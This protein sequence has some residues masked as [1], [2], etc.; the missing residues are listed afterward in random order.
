[1]VERNDAFWGAEELERALVCPGCGSQSLA[2]RYTGLDDLLGQVPGMWSLDQCGGCQSLCL[3]PRP[4]PSAIGKAYACEY[5]THASSIE[6]HRRDNGTSAIWKWANGYLNHRFGCSRSPES[7]LGRWLIPVFWPLRQQL[8]YFYRHLPRKAGR[9]LDIGCGNGAFLLRARDAGWQVEGLEPDTV[10]STH[11]REAGLRVHALLPEAFQPEELFDRITLS[12]V[13]E[14]VHEPRHLLTNCKRFLRSGGEIWLSL[15]N[16]SG[17]GHRLYGRNWFALD[18]P[19]HLFLPTEAM[20]R[21]M[22]AE[23]GFVEIQL[24]RRGR[25]AATTLLPSDGYAGIRGGKRHNVKMWAAFI[26]FAASLFGC[27][28]EEIV[29]SARKP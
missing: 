16:I 6:A 13:F 3:N 5:N 26:D 20:L 15:P 18:P 24:R 11:A 25:G 7:S 19:R 17:L 8:D 14:H 1:M 27:A 21:Q 2:A 12:H 22:L 4:V 10:A 28:S 9:L 29:I 23:T